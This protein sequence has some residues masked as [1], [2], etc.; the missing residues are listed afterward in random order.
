MKPLTVERARN[1]L[2]QLTLLAPLVSRARLRCVLIGSAAALLHGRGVTV[3]DVD[4]L[5]PDDPLQRARL[6]RVAHGLGATVTRP[7]YR[8]GLRF[9]LHAPDAGLHVDLVCAAHG[10]PSYATLRRRAV[11][12]ALGDGGLWVAPLEDVLRSRR[13]RALLVGRTA[14]ARAPSAQ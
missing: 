8:L 13:T 11:R 12:F 14:P 10:L 9:H 3:G 1:T 2:E 6:A 4:F 5:F 7:F